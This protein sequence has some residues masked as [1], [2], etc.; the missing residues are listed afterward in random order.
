MLFVE[1]I[2]AYTFVSYGVHVQPENDKQ[3]A[4]TNCLTESIGHTIALK[5]LVYIG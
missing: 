4:A 1:L 2:S 5:C 3:S